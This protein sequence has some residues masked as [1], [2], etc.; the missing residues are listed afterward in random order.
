MS[1]LRI[2]ICGCGMI[3]EHHLKAIKL[4][5]CPVTITAAIDPSEVR[6]VYGYRKEILSH[7]RALDCG[8]YRPPDLFFGASSYTVHDRFGTAPHFPAL[9]FFRK[10]N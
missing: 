6:D 10:K 7:K 8:M 2:G 3:A 9:R 5:D 4:W 1:N